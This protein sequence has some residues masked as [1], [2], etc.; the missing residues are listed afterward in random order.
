MMLGAFQSFYRDHN[1]YGL[2]STFVVGL[3]D[4][5]KDSVTLVKRLT[6]GRR[7]QKPRPEPLTSDIKHLNTSLR[8]F[9]LK[10]RLAN[11]S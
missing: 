8:P 9:T 10:H 1:E 4:L 6:D 11:L 3:A 5:L 7:L 2:R